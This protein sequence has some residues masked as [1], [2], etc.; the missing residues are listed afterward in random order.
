MDRHN[1]IRRQRYHQAKLD[2]YVELQGEIEAR[3]HELTWALRD[4][5]RK[6]AEGAVR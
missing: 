3:L 2:R 1:A 6:A 5:E 4:L